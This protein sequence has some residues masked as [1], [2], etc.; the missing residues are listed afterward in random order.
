MAADASIFLPE[1]LV[2]EVSE[3][4]AQHQALFAQLEEIKTIC[5]EGKSICRLIGRKLC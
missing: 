3:I 5:V 4:D 1:E 2:L